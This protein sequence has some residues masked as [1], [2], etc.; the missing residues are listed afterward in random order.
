MLPPF[1]TMYMEEI[2]SYFSEMLT[3]MCKS[4]DVTTQK[5]RIQIL[6]TL[7]NLY[8]TKVTVAVTQVRVKCL[9]NSGQ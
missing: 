5:A 9:K 1:L 3:I 2:C 4:T 7:F 8:R 6:T